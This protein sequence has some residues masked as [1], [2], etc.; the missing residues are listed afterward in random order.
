MAEP[1]PVHN[2]VRLQKTHPNLYHLIM[3]LNLS[4]I[5]LALNFWI[6]HPTF[7]P[8]GINKDLIGCIFFALGSIQ[9]VFLNFHRDLRAVRLVMAISIGFNLFWGL[10]NA[11][12]SFAGKASFQLPILYITL[13]LIRVP[14]MFESPVNPMT[15]RE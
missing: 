14:L 2:R 5:A 9:I 6:S 10:S 1:K 7:N 11:Q 12:Q 3:I 13:A 15:E 4:N 8:Y